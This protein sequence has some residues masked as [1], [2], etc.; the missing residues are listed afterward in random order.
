MA[1]SV[2]TGAAFV[3]SAHFPPKRQLALRG[4]VRKEA[5]LSR[6]TKES[7][8]SGVGDLKEADVEDVPVPG[9]SVRVRG[10]AARFSAEI[11]SHARLQMEGNEQTL[12]VDQATIERLQ[13]AHGV[14]DPQFTEH[15]AGQVAEKYGPAFRK[16][17]AKINELSG[18]DDEDVAAV[19]ARFPAGR[20]GTNGL[21]RGELGADVAGAST[22]GGR[23]AV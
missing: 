13:F 6:S 15:E 2:L 3:R 10:L 21:G 16:V 5:A 20:E 22:A 17:L 23:P 14:V 18:T 9:E 8:L 1:P 7:W 4:A 19:E 12:T 11:Q